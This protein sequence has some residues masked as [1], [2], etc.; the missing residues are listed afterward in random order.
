[1]VQRLERYGVKFE[2]DELRRVRGAAGAPVRFVR[3]ADARG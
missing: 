1:M 2:K 3:A